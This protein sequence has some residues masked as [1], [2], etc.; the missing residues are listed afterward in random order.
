VV[1]W[2]LTPVEGGTR[3]R[4][5]QSGFGPQDDNNYKGA[6]YGWQRFIGALE[7]VVA[8]LDS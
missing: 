4:M 6:A 2:T 3:V 5:E 7:K 1:A 8:K